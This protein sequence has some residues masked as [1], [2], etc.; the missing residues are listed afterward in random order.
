MA[1]AAPRYE[2][3]TMDDSTSLQM[4]ECLHRFGAIPVVGVADFV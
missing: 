3:D 1:D 4:V 2:L